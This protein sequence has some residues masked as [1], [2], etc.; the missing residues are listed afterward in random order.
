MRTILSIH[1][2][3]ILKDRKL[4]RRKKVY[5]LI[6]IPAIFTIMIFLNITGGNYLGSYSVEEGNK[7]PDVDKE[8]SQLLMKRGL[9]K[10]IRVY[11]SDN[12]VI[13]PLKSHPMHGKV[14]ILK[15]IKKNRPSL[16]KKGFLW[17]PIFVSVSESQDFGY[18]YGRYEQMQNNTKGHKAGQSRHYVTVWKKEPDRKWKIIFNIG[19]IEEVNSEQD[20]RNVYQIERFNGLEKE[21]ITTDTEF[22]DISLK[23]GSLEAF[24]NFISD[25]G[26][27]ISGERSPPAGKE[28]LREL[29]DKR[30]NE[31]GSNR[32]QLSWKPLFAYVS[33]AG[34]LGYTMGRYRSIPFK[35]ND[36]KAL[37]TGYY[38]TIWKRQPDGTWR[39]VFDMGNQLPSR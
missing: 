28:M 2:I 9:E 22:S 1:S 16:E 18:T 10:A 31:Q 30:K 21:L 32:P 8:F 17:E 33:S 27:F 36:K 19:L 26:I 3:I 7:L 5:G 39:F 24:Y 29:M 4:L 6:R 35:S 34:D 11:L 37:K 14:S 13:L 38:L 12:A 23:S 15:L 20:S 25:E